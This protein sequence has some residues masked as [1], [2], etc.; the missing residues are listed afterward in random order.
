[1]K[2]CLFFGTNPKKSIPTLWAPA[3]KTLI[4]ILGTRQNF[5]QKVDLSVKKSVLESVDPGVRIYLLSSGTDQL[6]YLFNSG[7]TNNIAATSF[8]L[9]LPRDG[10][11]N[12]LDPSSGK[13]IFKQD[14]T[15]G[16]NLI[17]TPDF[18]ID[19]AFRIDLQEP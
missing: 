19:L 11:V 12:W 10:T 3:F 1:M 14:L 7:A 6:G 9:D 5:T 4:S 16:N 17:T 15:R 8:Y 2:V 18:K 13:L